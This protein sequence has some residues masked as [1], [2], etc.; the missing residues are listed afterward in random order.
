MTREEKIRAIY[1]A[2][3]QLPQGYNGKGFFFTEGF[4]LNASETVTVMG[5]FTSDFNKGEVEVF[6]YGDKLFAKD[7]IGSYKTLI[8]SKESDYVVDE[9]YN[10][11]KKEPRIM[12]KFNE[13]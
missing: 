4:L 11:A 9:I 6:V 2:L 13:E 3:S 10:A 7:V 1:N 5:L 8:L 12:H